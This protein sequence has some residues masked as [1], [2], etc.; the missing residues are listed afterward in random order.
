MVGG[1]VGEFCEKDRD[2]AEKTAITDAKTMK[3]WALRGE[4]MQDVTTRTRNSFP[5][6]TSITVA[7]MPAAHLYIR[8]D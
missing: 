3:R 1:E 8:P 7:V 4:T 2:D 6:S 5:A